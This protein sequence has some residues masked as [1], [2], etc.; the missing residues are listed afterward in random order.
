[1]TPRPFWMYP[2]TNSSAFSSSTPS[3]SSRRSSSSALS[4]SA[5][6][7]F[8]LTSTGLSCLL[9]LGRLSSKLSHLEPASSP[10]PSRVEKTAAPSAQCHGRRDFLSRHSRARNLT[11]HD[12]WLTGRAQP[13]GRRCSCAASRG[14]QSP[15]H[16]RH[17]RAG[18]WL[19]LSRLTSTRGLALLL[20]EHQ[21]QRQSAPP[22]LPFRCRDHSGDLRKHA[23]EL[24]SWSPGE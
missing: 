20:G 2:A 3:T 22:S 19:R 23:F 10:D 7:W 5:L 8:G 18:A 4:S 6:L 13:G 14:S 21:G 17:R 11:R 12:S 24:M 16:L 15:G 1:L 9:P